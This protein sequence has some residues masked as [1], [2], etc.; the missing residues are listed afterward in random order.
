MAEISKLKPPQ[1]LNN[2]RFPKKNFHIFFSLNIV[3][4]SYV[5]KKFFFCQSSDVIF[6]P[7][8]LKIIE[9]QKTYKFLEN[10]FLAVCQVWF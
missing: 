10:K 9:K 6:P 5:K 2:L 8:T 1:N 7:K 4:F 3:F